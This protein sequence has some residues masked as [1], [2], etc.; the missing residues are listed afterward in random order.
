MLPTPFEISC[1]SSA[2]WD[3][4]SNEMLKLIVCEK[5]NL[6]FKMLSAAVV[7]RIKD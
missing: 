3:D 4:D 2:G 1:E 5:K 6:Y 7:L